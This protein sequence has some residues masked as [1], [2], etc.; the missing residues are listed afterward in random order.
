MNNRRSERWGPGD[1]RFPS[2]GVLPVDANEAVRGGWRGRCGEVDGREVHG[3]GLD[4]VPR[5]G[6]RGRCWGGGYGATSPA[7][8]SV[9]GENPWRLVEELRRRVETLEG[10]LRG[11]TTASDASP[12]PET[13]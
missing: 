1:G 8:G 7:A 5:G 10:R 11:E 9:T 3:M 13:R 12:T 4:G 6:G 2:E